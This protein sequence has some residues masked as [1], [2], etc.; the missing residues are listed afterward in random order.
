MPREV[1]IS[2][3]MV[4]VNTWDGQ[5]HWIGDK[6]KQPVVDAKEVCS[7]WWNQDASDE[8]QSGTNSTNGHQ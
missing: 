6:K 5:V 7:K 2:V 3:K 4:N 1:G 8:L